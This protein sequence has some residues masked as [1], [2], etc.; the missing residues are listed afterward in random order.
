LNHFTTKF[1]K[2]HFNRKIQ[3]FGSKSNPVVFEKISKNFEDK[4]SIMSH[5]DYDLN[6]VFLK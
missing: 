2:L 1:R 6:I 4:F 5:N 3:Y